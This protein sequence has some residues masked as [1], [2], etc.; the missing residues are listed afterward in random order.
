MGHFWYKS[1]GEKGREQQQLGA[2]KK[3]EQVY[4][5]RI[6]TP[7]SLNTLM[8]KASDM[9][10]INLKPDMKPKTQHTCNGQ[11]IKQGWSHSGQNSLS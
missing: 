2:W 7:K 6:F 10:F 8:F 3:C 1:K 9:F 5:E 11:S 4:L